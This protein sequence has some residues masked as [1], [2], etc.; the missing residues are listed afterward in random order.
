[1]HKKLLVIG[2]VWP[3]PTS[4]AA[5]WRMLQLLDLFLKR[6]YE[7]CFSSPAL[8]SPFSA[9]LSA[10]GIQEKSIQIND[11]S[12]ASF[13]K[14]F[15][16]SVVL[17]DRFMMEEQLGWRIRE[18]CPEALTILD[19]EDLHFLRKAR[20]E[21]FKQSVPLHKFDLFAEDAKRE[22]ASILRCDLSLIISEVEMH[23]LQRKFEMKASKLFYLPFIFSDSFTDSPQLKTFKD[24]QG[25]MCIGN[26][27]HQP[28]WD[29][30]LYLKQEIWPLIK[31]QL[32]K[33]EIEVYGAYCTSKVQ[34]L[35][36]PKEGFL[37]K[38]RAGDISQL[39]LEKRL[40][41]A[42]IRF[43]AGLKGKLVDAMRFGLPS[44]TTS[45]GAEGIGGKYPWPGEIANSPEE[46]ASKAVRLYTSSKPWHKAQKNAFQILNK[47]FN[48]N[49]FANRLMDTIHYKLS[50]LEQLRKENFIGEILHHHHLKSTKYMS[51]WI[52]EKNKKL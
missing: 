52:E 41:L 49:L 29:Q 17:F 10:L 34:Q 27:L 37:I 2:Y 51:L 47:R 7:I 5:G 9:D 11:S 19:T 20:Q 16:P 32:P 33:A 43:G 26:F 28:N 14:E 35:H 31:K 38:G 4:S 6:G 8:K 1:M 22:I 18:Q 36:Q 42:P 21:A 50:N 23:L 30:V 39:M 40:L 13:L 44:I 48:S 24:R 45:V 3:E 15:N 46:M 12:I 25:F